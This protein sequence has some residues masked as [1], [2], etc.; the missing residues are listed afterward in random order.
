VDHLFLHY[1]VLSC[2]WSW[3]C[4]YNNCSFTCN[5]FSDLWIIDANFSYKNNDICEIIRG[6][7]L[8]TI[9][10]E[11][12]KIVFERAKCKS[13]RALGNSIITLAKYW[14]R[15]KDD[16]YQFNL[17]LILPQNITMLPVQVLKRSLESEPTGA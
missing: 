13:L 12:N 6:A 2:L 5:T 15:K 7:F 11:R 1:T 10:K 17:H 3:I 9:W 8:W 14:C 16:D 4:R